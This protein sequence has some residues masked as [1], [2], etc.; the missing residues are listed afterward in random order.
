MVRSKTNNFDY[1][2]NSL[3]LY[4]PANSRLR[5]EQTFNFNLGLD[6][7][8][9]KNVSGNIDYYLKKSLDVLAA[10]EVDPTRGVTS[11]IINESTIR[12]GGLEVSL[13]ADWIQRRTFN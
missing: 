6:Y 3:G 5:W 12:N 7:R 11:A 1:T 8:I 9:F 10:N 13:N 4:S 2:L